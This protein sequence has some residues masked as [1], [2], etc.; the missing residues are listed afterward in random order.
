MVQHWVDKTLGLAAAGTSGHQGVVS[1]VLARQARP[2]SLLMT[3]PRKLGLKAVK[4]FATRC[5]RGK[6]QANLQIWSLEPTR[7]VFHKAA[8]QPV[9]EV[10]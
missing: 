9:H 5:T 7:L 1:Q 2:G 6:R 4:E 10:V 8:H 3:K